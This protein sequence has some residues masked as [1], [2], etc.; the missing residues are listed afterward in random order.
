MFPALTANPDLSTTFFAIHLHTIDGDRDQNDGDAQ[1]VS[2]LWVSV[3]VR[4]E[5]DCDPASGF[6]DYNDGLVAEEAIE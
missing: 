6:T 5:Q 2:V 1:S 4:V 3:C